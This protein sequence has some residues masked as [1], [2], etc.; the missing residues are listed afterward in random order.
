MSTLLEFG[1]REGYKELERLGDKL[2]D[3]ESLIDWEPFRPIINEMYNNKT[4]S[5][6]RPNI[7]EIVM[8]KMLVLQQWHG[9]SDSE[10]EKQATDRISFR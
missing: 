8:L 1:L 5:G 9:L 3:I 10:M 2:S 7:D 4:E 6:G